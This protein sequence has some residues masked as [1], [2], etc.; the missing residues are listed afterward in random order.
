MNQSARASD[1]NETELIARIST[2][3]SSTDEVVLGP[4]DDAAIVRAVDGNVV[5]STD[6]LVE[7]QHFHREW[8]T[9]EALGHRCIAQNVADIAAMGGRPTAVVVALVLPADV[10]VEWIDDLARGMG[11]AC[12]AAGAS[13]VGGDLSAGERISISVTVLGSLDGARPVLRS[14]ARAGDVVALAG[15]CGWSAAGY[16]VLERAHENEDAIPAHMRK[17]VDRH[18]VPDPPLAAGIA[19]NKAGATAMLDVSD[20][21]VRDAERI[22]HASGATI[23]IDGNVVQDLAQPLTAAGNYTGQDPQNWVL[24]GGEDHGMLATF[25]ASVPLPQGFVAIGRVEAPGQ[26]LVLVDEAIPTE[27]VG[28]D[29]FETE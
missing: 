3:L 16:A 2:H 12:R 24:G 1:F 18:F 4:G 26:E 22:A 8:I 10:L 6:V 14:G 11:D 23:N 20:G 5:V 7:N 28:W 21:M 27:D 29:H 25:P 19:A 9:A 13:V 15:N 17:F